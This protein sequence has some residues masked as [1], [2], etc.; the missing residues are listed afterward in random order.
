MN[1]INISLLPPEI[2]N[3]QRARRRTDYY[4]LAVSVVMLFFLGVYLVFLGITFQV[5]AEVNALRKERAALQEEIAAYQ[6]YA[7][8]EEQAKEASRMLGDAMGT[9]PDWASLLADLSLHLPEG[10]WLESLSAS[11]QNTGGASKQGGGELTFRGWV[12]SRAVVDGRL[13][14]FGAVPGLAEA[15]CRLTTVESTR[16][17]LEFTARILPGD[18]YQPAFRGDAR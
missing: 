10:V 7:T 11:Y 14:E 15:R 13:D 1:K 8:L 3:R 17:G 9:T 16:L 5:R 18:P 6:E 4:L 12:I 2:R